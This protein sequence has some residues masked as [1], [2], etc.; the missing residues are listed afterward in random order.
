MAYLS[1]LST[2]KCPGE[3][4]WP[5]KGWMIANYCLILYWIKEKDMKGNPFLNAMLFSRVLKFLSC[6]F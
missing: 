1:Y 3:G 2:L 6:L 5:E 4:A